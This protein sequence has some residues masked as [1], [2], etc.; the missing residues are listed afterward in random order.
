[1]PTDCAF[2]GLFAAAVG[3]LVGLVSFFRGVEDDDDDDDEEEDDEEV[4]VVG[5]IVAAAVVACID[6]DT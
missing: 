5:V 3:R 2:R 4:V 6:G 1:M